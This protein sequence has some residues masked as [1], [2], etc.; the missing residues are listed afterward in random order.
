MPKWY[1][2]GGTV[3]GLDKA[4]VSDTSGF[5]LNDIVEMLY[6]GPQSTTKK[7]NQKAQK[8]SVAKVS[9]SLKQ[10]GAVNAKLDDVKKALDHWWEST[11]RGND[12]DRDVI[13]EIINAV[14]W[15]KK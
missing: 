8:E 6:D 11:L 3:G 2:Y 10:W 12:V 15:N 4:S 5:S 1:T 9:V 14:G 13:E 7:I